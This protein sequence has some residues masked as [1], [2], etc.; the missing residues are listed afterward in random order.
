M[1]RL[2]P[3]PA[4]AGNR[5]AAPGGPPD[6]RLDVLAPP[7]N[8]RTAARPAVRHTPTPVGGPAADRAPTAPSHR[9]NRRNS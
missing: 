6:R 7:L 3:A 1:L 9:T 8:R 4:P 2:T 5:A